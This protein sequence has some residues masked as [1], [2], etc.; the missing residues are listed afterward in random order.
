MKILRIYRRL[1]ALPTVAMMMF[2]MLPYGAAQ[3]AMISTEQA[4][5]TPT[6]MRSASDARSHV[7]NLL[8]RADV[9]AEM[10]ALGVD[11]N[12]AIERAA[13]MS[14]SEIQ[15]VANKL[16]ESPAG[17]GVILGIVGAVILVFFVLL[18]T[19]ILCLT[20]IFPFTKCI[21]NKK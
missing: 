10:R 1:I 14:D 12:E 13:A 5:A 2:L 9:Q 17:R 7:V 15:H 6:S 16:D 20:S 3:A 21:D 8:Q 18:V 19:D 11:P 4:V